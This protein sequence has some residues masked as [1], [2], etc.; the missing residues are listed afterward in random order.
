MVDGIQFDFERSWQ[1]AKWDDSPWYRGGIERLQ[2]ELDGRHEGTKAADLIGLRGAS[3]YLIEVKDFR[4]FTIENKR[5]QVRELP[6]EIGLKARDTIAAVAGLVSLG[7]PPELPVRWLR[8]VREEG[9]AVNVVAWIAEDP[10]PAQPEHQRARAEIRLAGLKQKL[11]W[12]T[13]RVWVCDPLRQI[14]LEDVSAASLAGAG[15]ARQP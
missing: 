6:L 10:R 1:V 4:G 12:L 5:R 13:R 3:P 8:A 15:A 14:T 11:A 7:N 9:R 2:G